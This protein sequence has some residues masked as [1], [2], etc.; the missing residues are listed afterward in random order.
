MVRKVY[1][2]PGEV[3]H[4]SKWVQYRIEQWKNKLRF[5]GVIL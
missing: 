4:R 3:R 2:H 5:W 1:G